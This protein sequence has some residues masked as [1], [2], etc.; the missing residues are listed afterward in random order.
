MDICFMSVF[1]YEPHFTD[2]ELFEL[3]EEN[4]RH[5]GQVL[6]MRV[7]DS[8]TLINGKGT[9]GSVTITSIQKKKLLVTVHQKE[10]IPPPPNQLTIAVGMLKNH[11][12]FEWML[13]KL[14]EIGVT[15]IV[16]LITQRTERTHFKAD[17]FQ[18]IIAAAMVQSQQFWLPQ[19]Q[20][21]ITLHQFLDK[22]T[23]S[24]KL[25]AHCEKDA[26]TILS[27]HAQQPSTSILIGP[28][29]DFTEEEISIALSKNYLSVT[30]GATRLR[31]E[32]AAIV[33][34]SILKISK[35]V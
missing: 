10:E 33:A 2:K 8:I 16:P 20:E 6:R 25:I 23:S 22:D 13:E 4:A 26:K 3:S 7:G 18:K 14:T 17:R 31:T 19:L 5:F 28:E 35:S 15:Q 11:S 24:V 30:L 1:C 9:A 32:T 21:P 12:R 27:D 34:A 29:G